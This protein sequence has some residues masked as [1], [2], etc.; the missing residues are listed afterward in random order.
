MLYAVPITKGLYSLGQERIAFN[1][2]TRQFMFDDH[3]GRRTLLSVEDVMKL[4]VDRV[5][6][7]EMLRFADR[8]LEDQR[9]PSKWESSPTKGRRRLEVLLLKEE[10]LSCNC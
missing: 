2:D 8:T 3:L 4:P 6:L 10:D 9:A 1:A 5:E 7:E